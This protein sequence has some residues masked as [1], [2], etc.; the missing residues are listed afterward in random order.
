MSPRDAPGSEGGT[1][2]LL[3]CGGVEVLRWPLPGQPRPDLALIDELA[4]W[5]LIAGR[6]GCHLRLQHVDPHL[7]ELLHLT[8]LTDIVVEADGP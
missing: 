5:Q 8:G 1:V 4:R 2:I 6:L 3:V 7:S